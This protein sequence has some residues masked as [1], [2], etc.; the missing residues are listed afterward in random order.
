MP[1][2][3]F[4]ALSLAILAASL[5]LPLQLLAADTQATDTAEGQTPSVRW[6]PSRC[7]AACSAA[8]SPMMCSA[9]PVAAR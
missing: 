7:K 9:T 1:T 3:R 8:P 4:Q 6:T 5:S 2:F